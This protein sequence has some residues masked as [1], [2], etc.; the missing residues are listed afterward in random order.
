[1]KKHV[2]TWTFRPLLSEAPHKETFQFPS[3]RCLNS[4]AGLIHCSQWKER[5]AWWL[6]LSFSSDT[7]TLLSESPRPKSP[8]E[9]E[10]VWQNRAVTAC[11]HRDRAQILCLSVFPPY[12]L[13]ISTFL[14][15]ICP[16]CLASIPSVYI[17]PFFPRSPSLLSCSF[18]PFSPLLCPRCTS[19]SG[20]S[21]V[22]CTRSAP[23][24]FIFACGCCLDAAETIR[25]VLNAAS[26]WAPHWLVCQHRLDF[27]CLLKCDFV[28]C[29]VHSNPTEL[30]W[31]GARQIW[32]GS[33]NP[34]RVD[35]HTNQQRTENVY[36][37]P[38][39]PLSLQ[40]CSAQ[41][42]IFVPQF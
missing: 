2:L 41:T 31:I 26:H 23:C 42:L 4:W 3:S 30:W 12:F 36:F 40:I 32:V 18:A 37:S 13:F 28:C 9:H 17:F 39:S 34:A 16:L 35:W 22:L 8:K 10:S 20:N 25:S 7:G 14:T 21:S 1:M 27:Q 6:H 29:A 33:V 15:F 5:P 11:L 24:G 19:W 38:I